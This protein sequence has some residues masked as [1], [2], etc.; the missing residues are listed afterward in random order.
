MTTCDVNYLLA[1]IKINAFVFFHHAFPNQIDH[2][3]H[4]L[5]RKYLIEGNAIAT[6]TY[7]DSRNH[8][9]GRRT[10]SPTNT[11]VISPDQLRVSP[12]Y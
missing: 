9:I 4:V 8:A 7:R 10:V 6:S 11:A 1:N 12:T 2:L 3:R 5:A